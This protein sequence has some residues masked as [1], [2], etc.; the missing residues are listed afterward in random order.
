MRD[1]RY[2]ILFE[3][4]QIGPVTARNR[5]YQV[6]HCNGLG[7]VFPK[8]E[9]AMRG[10][11]A[12]G[13]W[14]VVST[15]EVDIHHS[16][17]SSPFIE[18]RLWDEG[19]MKRLA[20]MAEAAHEHNSLAA[21]EL[22]HNGHAAHNAQSKMPSL[23]VSDMVIDNYSPAQCAT[24]TKKDIAAIRRWHRRAALRSRDA[25]FDIIYVYAGHDL[26]L[27][28]H[29][30]SPNRNTRTDEYGGS[31]ENRAR[32]LKEL[33]EDTKDAVGDT[34]GIAVRLA[35][36]ELMGDRGTQW[37]VEGKAV[38]EM[39]AEYP[40][41]WDVNISDWQHDSQTSRFSGE[42]FQEQY[43]RFVKEI[44]SKPVVGVGRFTSPDTM[45][46]Q[47]RRGVLD[48]IG[49][50][51]P[52]IADPFLPKKIEEGRLDDIRECIGCNICVASDMTVMPIRCTQNPTV[53]E[54]FRRAWH[55]EIIAP[56]KTEDHV[57][58]IGAGPAGLEA[59]LSLGRRGHDVTVAEA[60]SEAGGRATTESRLP[61]LAAWKRVADY[62][63]GQ[64]D[65][66]ENVSLHLESPLD[67]NQVL[68][69]A[70]ELGVSRV[71]CATGSTWC[72]DGIGREHR[73]VIPR[74][75]SVNVHTPDDVMTGF[76]P[77]TNVVVY[78]DDH[79]YMGGVI[80]EA[81]ISQGANVTLVTPAADVSTWTHNTL[82]QEYIEKHLHHLGVAIIEKHRLIELAAGTVRLE[83]TLSGRRSEV[84]ASDLVMVTAR[85]INTEL[86]LS[87]KN[88]SGLDDAGIVEV[89]RIGDCVAPSTIAAAVFSGH[90][91]AQEVGE[92]LSPDD[93]PFR[94]EYVEI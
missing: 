73:A 57:L 81:M 68:E 9:A 25:G 85:R 42:G 12:A 44:T 51:R 77:G 39:L 34:C 24:V 19:D 10:M 37:E 49:A 64:I 87:L 69:F 63:L 28:S 78:D 4:V 7:H 8:G 41:I 58:V 71:L 80:A 94:R 15:Q 54:E 91:Y 23:A 89:A 75:E 93:V 33:L 67:R 46:S 66:L 65:K 27:A 60:R 11:K 79:Y 32:F 17:D 74:D 13:G 31:I 14:A 88:D 50:A 36:D 47:I 53:G 30:L 29:F 59:A 83:H 1:P 62:R 84:E 26:A 52:S 45:V 43:T 21:I 90:T 56:K 6:P 38:V 92:G 5:F 86:Y 16:S 55:P 3:P 82:E 20:L 61:G 70:G 18:G 48:M 35:V 76:V 22:T 2:D 72:R 40:D